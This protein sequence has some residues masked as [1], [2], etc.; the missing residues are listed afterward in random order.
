MP[1]EGMPG[2]RS[3]LTHRKFL[4]Q[5]L[6]PASAQRRTCRTSAGSPLS[7]RRLSLLQNAELRYL[8]LQ[9]EVR[10]VDA[11]LQRMGIAD[12]G[13]R[14]RVEGALP[15]TDPADLLGRGAG[16]SR[17]PAGP[18]QPLNGAARDFA[19]DNGAILPDQADVGSMAPLFVVA[20]A[21]GGL[22]GQE[23]AFAAMRRPVF[24]LYLPE[25]RRAQK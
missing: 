7:L 16:A 5:V 20:D 10:D 15:W 3:D 18:V 2:S 23:A 17:G 14:A 11:Y 9:G 12:P 1:R 13:L 21:T 19:W 22:A 6:K 4:I 25:A 8:L 24:A